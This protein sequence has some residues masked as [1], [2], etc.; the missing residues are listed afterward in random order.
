MRTFSRICLVAAVVCS[1]MFVTS[2]G[3]NALPRGDS[4]P[5]ARAESGWLEAAVDWFQNL[6]DRGERPHPQRGDKPSAG[7]EKSSMNGAC[8]DPLGRPRSCPY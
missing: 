2:P 4:Q 5:E 1:L 6:L 3:A 8:I 7:K